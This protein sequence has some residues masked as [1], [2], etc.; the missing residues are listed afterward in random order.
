MERHTFSFT[1]FLIC[2]VKKLMQI[3]RKHQKLIKFKN[4]KGAQ[5]F[6]LLMDNSAYSFFRRPTRHRRLFRR[7][8]SLSDAETAS[9]RAGDNLYHNTISCTDRILHHWRTKANNIASIGNLLIV[10]EIVFCQQR[11]LSSLCVAFVRV[12]IL[13]HCV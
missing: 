6:L 5:G 4:S 9:V 1:I 2:K 12:K 10:L 7:G 3:T 13:L 11:S 8:T